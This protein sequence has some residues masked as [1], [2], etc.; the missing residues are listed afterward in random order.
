MGCAQSTVKVQELTPHEKLLASNKSRQEATRHS[1][2]QIT[3]P[4]AAPRM[5]SPDEP[6][7]EPKK[8]LSWSD[9]PAPDL[10]HKTG[11]MSIYT[12]D[13]GTWETCFWELAQWSAD[14]RLALRYK[15]RRGDESWLDSW[16]L[17][18]AAEI[19]R[20]A[21]RSSL[22]QRE[23]LSEGCPEG[24]MTLLGLEPRGFTDGAETDT[25]VR[26]LRPSAAPFPQL[27]EQCVPLRPQ[28]LGTRYELT[29]DEWA[30]RIEEEMQRP[31]GSEARPAVTVD[32]PTA[33]PARTAARSSPRVT[34]E[35]LSLRSPITSPPPPPPPAPVDPT[36]QGMREGLAARRRQAGG[37]NPEREFAPHDP[38]FQPFAH[39]ASKTNVR[40][41]TP[42]SPSCPATALITGG[43]GVRRQWPRQWQSSAGCRQWMAAGTARRRRGS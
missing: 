29:I 26:A 3:P 18:E 12:V 28:V 5:R 24:I 9:G 6:G 42:T 17:G 30:D 38:D 27:S 25:L 4:V 1:P 22:S 7:A 21:Q 36:D 2:R 11:S 40:H 8:Q 43:C 39:V 20:G 13:T 15:R 41:T 14:G 35:D 23:R 34:V 37:L 10:A 33:S 16:R 32:T 19:R 31:P